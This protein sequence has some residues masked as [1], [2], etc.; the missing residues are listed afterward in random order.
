MVDTNTGVRSGVAGCMQATVRRAW[1]GQFLACHTRPIV[2]GIIAR[3]A[4][5]VLKGA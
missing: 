5:F 1:I 4:C 3:G 2:K